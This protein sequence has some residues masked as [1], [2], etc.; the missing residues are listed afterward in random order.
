MGLIRYLVVLCERGQVGKLH[1]QL[2]QSLTY[3]C[4]EFRPIM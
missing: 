3:G 4:Q 1:L 2:Q